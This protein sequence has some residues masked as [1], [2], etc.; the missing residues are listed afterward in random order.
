MAGIGHE[1][2]LALECLLE[3]GEH[4][5]QGRARAGRSR[6]PPSVPAASRRARPSDRGGPPAHPL[7]RAQRGGGD[8]VARQGGE[9]QRDRPADQQQRGEALRARRCGPPASC[10]PPRSAPRPRFAAEWRAAGPG[11]CPPPRTLSRSTRSSPASRAASSAGVSSG[12][13]LR[14]R[15]GIDDA[16]VRRPAPA[17]SSRPARRAACHPIGW[18]LESDS[19][20]SAVTESAR[21]RRPSSIDLSSSDSM[22]R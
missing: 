16:P 22:R 21:E 1:R 18:R 6:R 19:V 4:L 11:C 17:Q 15:R 5:V 10:R 2:A 9:Q 8:P 7:D 12:S 14:A 13:A 3:A 20:T